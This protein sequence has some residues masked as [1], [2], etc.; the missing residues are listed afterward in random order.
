MNMP[1]VIS[2]KGSQ[3]SYR[4]AGAADTRCW[5][6]VSRNCKSSVLCYTKGLPWCGKHRIWQEGAAAK[7]V[8]AAGR[9]I[10]S[11]QSVLP[12]ILHECL[13]HAACISKDSGLCMATSCPDQL[14]QSIHV[15]NVLFPTQGAAF[16]CTSHN[17]GFGT[18]RSVWINKRVN[19]L[20]CLH[21]LYLLKLAVG[22]FFSLFVSKGTSRPVHQIL[23]KSSCCPQQSRLKAPGWQSS[24]VVCGWCLS[25]SSLLGWEC[26]SHIPKGEALR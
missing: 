1:E 17:F 25:N 24:L 14:L 8:T 3:C 16:L 21:F 9:G 26:T 13:K 4:K 18:S 19:E 7:G 5:T 23:C 15:K 6:S 11:F 20:L 22:F 12:S 2:L 10:T